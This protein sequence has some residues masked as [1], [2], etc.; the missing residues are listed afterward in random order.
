MGLSEAMN[1][2]VTREDGSQTRS[3]KKQ[4]FSLNLEAD[5]IYKLDAIVLERKREQSGYSRTEL[6]EEIIRSYLDTEGK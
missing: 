5:L 3:G 4:R 6:L 1:N 2:Q